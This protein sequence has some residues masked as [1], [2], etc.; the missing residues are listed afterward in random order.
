MIYFLLL[1]VIADF[2]EN[3]TVVKLC[4]KT[5]SEQMYLLYVD[6]AIPRCWRKLF[7]RLWIENMLNMAFSALSIDSFMGH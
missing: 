6:S 3:V 4:D 5:H 2:Q 1:L 7:S